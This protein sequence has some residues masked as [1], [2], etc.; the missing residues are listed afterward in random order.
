MEQNI[1]VPAM[2]SVVIFSQAPTAASR[3]VDG[4]VVHLKDFQRRQIVKPLAEDWELHLV[5]SGDFTWRLVN[6]AGF[7][8]IDTTPA[9]VPMDLRATPS[10]RDQVVELVS[11]YIAARAQDDGYETLEEALDFDMAGEIDD[12]ATEAERAFLAAFAP[13]QGRAANDPP[14]GTKVPSK[15]PK[16]PPRADSGEMAEE[17]PTA[18]SEET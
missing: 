3:V 1:I 2:H 16:T 9:E 10:M 8:N 12:L 6:Q 18:E 5:S 14:P 4:V 17:Q 7:E 13:P 15:P 11:R